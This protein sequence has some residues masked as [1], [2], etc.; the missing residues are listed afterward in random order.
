MVKKVGKYELGRTLGE[1]TFG[2]VK[3]AINTET[4]EAVAIKVLDKEKI[5]KQ[6]MGNQIKKEI[7]IMKMVKHKYVVGMIEVLASKSKIFIVLELVTGGELFDKIVRD[8]KLQEETALFYLAQL[9]EGVA[10]C[11]KLGVCHRDLKPENL[12]LDENGNLKISDFGLSSLYVGD[13]NGDGASRTEILHTTCGTPNY[14]APE[15][16][17]DKGYDGKKADVWSIGV[18]LYV[19]MAGFLPFDESSIVALF[20]KIQNA[21]FTYPKWFSMEIRQVI[22]LMLVSDPANRV[23]LKD[24]MANEWLQEKLPKFAEGEDDVS[25]MAQAIAAEQQDV[26][27]IES[28]F[29][30][31]GD[32]TPVVPSVASSPEKAAHKTASPQSAEEVAAAMEKPKSFYPNKGPAAAAASNFADLEASLDESMG[33]SL[34]RPKILSAFDLINQVGG[35]A[36][37]K[38]FSPATDVEANASGHLVKKLSSKRIMAAGGAEG[39][40]QAKEDML[41]ADD[42]RL[43]S[44][45]ASVRFGGASNRRTGSYHYSSTIDPSTLMKG[46]YKALEELGF[47]LDSPVGDAATTG[48]CKG[49][50]QTPAKGMI[51]MNVFVYTLC[52]TLSLLEIRRARGNPFEWNKVYE[53]LI[54]NRIAN[55]INLPSGEGEAKADSSPRPGYSK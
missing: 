53:E 33:A 17:A 28:E 25:E 48:K 20:Q 13:A 55:L 35:F 4:Q 22:D 9:V 14:V 15:V 34:S 37:D 49:T 12:L 21:D 51:G 50:M 30:E 7:S 2:K 32:D 42:K 24:L 3:Y 11:H 52:S 46:V 8:G 31:G 29:G 18:I 54:T 27:G 44:R 19:L 26:G 1:G 36:L 43:L 41:T 45:T 10:Y 6:N 39:A 38:L 40:S 16:L 23:T 47:S 5:Q